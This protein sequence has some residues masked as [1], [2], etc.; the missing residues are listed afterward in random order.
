MEEIWKDIAGFEGL[1]QVSNMGNVKSLE[2]TV[3]DN[4]GY[5]RT[6]P[7]RI[8]KPRNTGKGYLAVNLYKDGK[9]KNYKIHRLVAQAF[10]PNPY[11]LPEVN[12]IDEDK[13]NNCV[14]NLEWCTSQ[15]NIEYSKAKAIIGIDKVT[16]LIVE[17]PSTKE[18]SRQT[19]INHG[20]ICACCNGKRNSAGGFYWIYANTDADAE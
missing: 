3:C 10:L 4:R 1:Y 19:G 12:H 16:G 18:A 20:N 15:Y 8:R 6:V 7:E 5:Y 9:A 13:Y 14:E 17:F 11:N 2:R